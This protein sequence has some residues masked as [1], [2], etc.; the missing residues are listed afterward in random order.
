MIMKKFS[1][2]LI[3]LLLCLALVACDGGDDEYVVITDE[4]GET[5]RVK[6]SETETESESQTESDTDGGLGDI[7]ADGGDDGDDNKDWT[8]NY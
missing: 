7:V 3:A 2:I 8:A 5:Q 1:L 6:K 4:N